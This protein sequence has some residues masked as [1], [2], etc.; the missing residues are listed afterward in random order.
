MNDPRPQITLI[1]VTLARV[2]SAGKLIVGGTVLDGKRFLK[3][4]SISIKGNSFGA[5][6][7]K[8]SPK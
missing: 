4:Y 1:H 7:Y 8:P 3:V 5:T 2:L 6:P